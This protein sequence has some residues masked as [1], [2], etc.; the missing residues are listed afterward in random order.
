MRKIE[1]W[2]MLLTLFKA[3]VPARAGGGPHSPSPALTV[4]H[5]LQHWLL[6]VEIQRKGHRATV[7]CDAVWQSRKEI[8]IW[9]ICAFAKSVFILPLTI[10]VTL[11]KWPTPT[12]LPAGLM[13]S[14]LIL[15]YYFTCTTW[16]KILW[17]DILLGPCQM[18][19]II[20]WV[21]SVHYS[22]AFLHQ[23]LANFS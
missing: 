5:W 23:G 10:Y 7:F 18:P 2:D 9:S 17:I 12:C 11:R 4:A 20:R 8:G 6:V 14:S 16:V 3:A 22:L 15:G 19:G 21:A 13:S 1:T